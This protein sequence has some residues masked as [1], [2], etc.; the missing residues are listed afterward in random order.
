MNVLKW[1]IVTYI[2]YTVVGIVFVAAAPG[3]MKL[4][5]PEGDF[6]IGLIFGVW[7]GYKMVEKGGKYY[8]GIIG[9]VVMGLLV[10]AVAVGFLIA[11]G[12]PGDTVSIFAV[13]MVTAH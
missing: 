9:G 2:V 3:I 4:Y 12:M 13:A 7:V 5:P 10:G 6:I 1:P 8:D 11:F